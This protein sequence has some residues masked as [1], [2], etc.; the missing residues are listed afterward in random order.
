MSN[1]SVYGGSRLTLTL[2][3]DL[4]EKMHLYAPGVAK[5]YIPIDW[6][7]AES[8]AYDVFPASYPP[9]RQLRLEAIDETVPVFEGK[10]R[11][12]REIKVAQFREAQK[13][14]KDGKIEIQGVFRYQACDDRVCYAP[15]T[16][17]LRW[18]LDLE[19]YDRQRAP[20]EL[21]GERP[22]N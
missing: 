20:A 3:L 17:P 13:A 19:E 7:I 12:L 6:T 15:Q 8:A 5:P 14:A 4:P 1:P 18:E 16:I 11:V 22:V 2:D 10:L 21:R 9:S